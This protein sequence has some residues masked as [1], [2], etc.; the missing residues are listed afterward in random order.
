M[1]GYYLHVFFSHFAQ[2]SSKSVLIST[3]AKREDE[4][5]REANHEVGIYYGGTK[6]QHNVNAIEESIEND[7]SDNDDEEVPKDPSQYELKERC[8]KQTLDT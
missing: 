6:E 4:W 3:D 1:S 2:G 7:D 8:T 5:L